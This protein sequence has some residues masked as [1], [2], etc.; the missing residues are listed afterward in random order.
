MPQLA[1]TVNQRERIEMTR[2]VEI[3][4]RDSGRP[5]SEY[6]NWVVGAPFAELVFEITPDICNEYAIAVTGRSDGYLIG[7]RRAAIP[8]IFG[9]YLNA[10]LLRM[11]YPPHGVMVDTRFRFH[12]PVWADE[13][14]WVRATG[15]ID[16]KFE[17]RNRKYMKWSAEFIG[18]NDN[19][20]LSANTTIAFA[21]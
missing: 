6:E 15:R 5:G 2:P 12:L 17:K 20:I 10:V 14:T 11:Y 7:N 21:Q 19:M 3:K 16:E 4:P 1:T 13:T 18:R 8:S 9:L